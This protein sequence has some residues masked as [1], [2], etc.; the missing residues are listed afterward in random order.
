MP[1]TFERFDRLE[2]TIRLA[3][4]RAPP[5]RPSWCAASSAPSGGVA[6]K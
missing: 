3:Y 1:G 5:L 4:G 6:P 2:N